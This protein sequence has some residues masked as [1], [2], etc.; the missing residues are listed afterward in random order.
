MSLRLDSDVS[1]RSHH[2]RSTSFSKK[3]EVRFF[4]FLQRHPPESTFIG[5]VVVLI[6]VFQV[7][8]FIINTSYFEQ[9]DSLLDPRALFEV[10]AL[11]VSKTSEIDPVTVFYVSTATLYVLL[12]ITGLLMIVPHYNL[13]FHIG[14][15]LI[16]LFTT[17]L[18][19]PLFSNLLPALTCLPS[20]ADVSF[21]SLVTPDR[22]WP[23]YGLLIKI[24][25]FVG[26]VLY[27]LLCYCMVRCSYDTSPF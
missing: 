26:L 6:T 21:H 27:Y 9:W 19:V 23:S 5:V 8:G 13:I 11:R 10:L 18:F 15:V 14:S 16:R 24:G 25:A 17:V 7:V 20:S 22:C 3:T 1:S 4:D 12:T 2:A